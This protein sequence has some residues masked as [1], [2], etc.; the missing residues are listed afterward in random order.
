MKRIPEKGSTLPF[1]ESQNKPLG[2]RER[3]GVSQHL[4]LFLE[5]ILPTK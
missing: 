5:K 2:S 3:F 4:Q 1:L